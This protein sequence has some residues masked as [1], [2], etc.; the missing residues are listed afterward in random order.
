MAMLSGA[1]ALVKRLRQHKVDTVFGLP[2]GQLDHMFDA[3][4]REGD[5]LKVIHSRH[6]QGVAYMAYGYARS[7]GREGVFAVVPGPGLLNA[8]GALCTAWGNNAQVLCVSGQIP[9]LA[10]DR[11]YGDLHEI[12]DQ[13]GMISHITKSAARIEHPT[14]APAA[15][16]EAFRQLNMM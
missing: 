3:M 1:Q 7:T 2:G 14:S 13:L 9:L 4:Y 10:I 15:V 5:D 6:E 11:G 12:P 16:D 8:S